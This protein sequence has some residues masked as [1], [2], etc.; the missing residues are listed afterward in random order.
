MIEGRGIPG[1][2]VNSHRRCWVLIDSAELC[3][4]QM[5]NHTIYIVILG[6]HLFPFARLVHSSVHKITTFT[7][8]INN[9][10]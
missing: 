4:R 3:V 2:L 6:R 9:T 5:F 7:F 1:A 8:S 10:D